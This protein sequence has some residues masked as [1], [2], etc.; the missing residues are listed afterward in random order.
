MRALVEKPPGDEGD[1]ED[2]QV[3]QHGGEPRAYCLD[4][5]VPEDQ[6]DGEEGAGEM[7]EPPRAHRQRAQPAALPRSKRGEHAQRQQAP[8][9]RRRRGRHVGQPY[10]RAGPRDAER[11]E[12]RGQHGAAADQVHGVASQQ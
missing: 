12:K 2:L 7:G 5:V 9:R 1:H 10:Q 6:V 11:A 4:G 3:S 8:E